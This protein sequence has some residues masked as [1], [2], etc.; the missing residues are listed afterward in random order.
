MKNSTRRKHRQRAG[1]DARN[2]RV[3]VAGQVAQHRQDDDRADDVVAGVG[4]SADRPAAGLRNARRMPPGTRSPKVHQREHD[5]QRVD[6]VE[7]VGDVAEQPLDGVVAEG[8]D[9]GDRRP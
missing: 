8:H 2:D 9:S 3:A 1:E 7:E 4:H 6:A 5:E